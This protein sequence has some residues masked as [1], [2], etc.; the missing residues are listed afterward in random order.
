MGRDALDASVAN[1]VE[2]SQIDESV[3]RQQHNHCSESSEPREPSP[4]RHQIDQLQCKSDRE[5]SH[6]EGGFDLANCNGATDRRSI[7]KSREHTDKVDCPTRCPSNETDRRSSVGCV[8]PKRE[9]NS[10]NRNN[11][12]TDVDSRPREDELSISG[13]VRDL[14]DS[15]VERNLQ[16]DEIKSTMIPG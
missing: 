3:E 8:T 4:A 10:A 6:S 9:S 5:T 1:D 2:V 7:G 11:V 16:Q 13:C 14:I 15:A 12:V